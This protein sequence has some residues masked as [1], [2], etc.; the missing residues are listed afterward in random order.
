MSWF[1][2]AFSAIGSA[3]KSVA[4]FVKPIAQA[5]VSAIPIVGP[6]ASALVGK[7]L[8]D[9]PQEVQQQAAEAVTQIA[10]SPPASPVAA[11]AQASELKQNLIA[12]GVPSDQASAVGAVAHGVTQ[13]SPMQATA[14]MQNVTTSLPNAPLAQGF[15]KDDVKKVVDGAVKGAKDGAVDAFLDETAEGQQ[16]KKD[17]IEAQGSKILPFALGG[18]LLFIVLKNNK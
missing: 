13:L 12:A 1:S 5:A 16:T 11:S 7:L 14:V 6:V 17:A 15:T 2:S 10:A 3:V 4:T 18:L 9:A 8:P